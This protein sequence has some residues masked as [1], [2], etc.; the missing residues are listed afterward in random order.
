MGE[1]LNLV[2][3]DKALK[4]VFNQLDSRLGTELVEITDSLNRVVA[5]D[6]QSLE[7]LP[8]FVRST[9]DGYSV[10]A[11]DTFGAS[12]SLPALLNVIGEISMGESLS[13]IHI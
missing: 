1:F 3:P 8:S 10:R 13:L 2:S 5:K 9:M 4:E 7:N 12:E 11:S 6:V